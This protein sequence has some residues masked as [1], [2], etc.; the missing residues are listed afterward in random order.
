MHEDITERKKNII[1]ILLYV[2]VTYGVCWIVGIANLYWKFIDGNTMA[3]FMMIL[4]ASGVSIGKL[5]KNIENDKNKKIHLLYVA[6]FSGFLFLILLR[7]INV[8]SEETVQLFGSNVFVILTSVLCLFFALLD[9][10]ELS[11][12]SNW[13]TVKR[14]LIAFILILIVCGAIGSIGLKNV[15]YSSVIYLPLSVITVVMQI[16][17]F[18]GEEYG[19]RGFLQEKMQKKFGKRMGVIFLGILWELWHMPIW[20]S[21]YDVD[22]I[23]VM[24]RFFSTTGLSIV[25]GYAYMKSKNVWICA[26][27]HFLFN[28]I[29]SSFPGNGVLNV[30]QLRTAPWQLVS[31]IIMVMAFYFFLFSK[32]YKK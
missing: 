7:I 25:I 32:E 24:L 30:V 1:E 10:E 13:R 20:V 29:Y 14:V 21:V 15:D 12:T 16:A 27:M 11:L 22:S 6:L 28:M 8:I 4:P 31:F 9:E 17:L 23:G 5:Y 26:F 18:F 19:W 3:S 2:A